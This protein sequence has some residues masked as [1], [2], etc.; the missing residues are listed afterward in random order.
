MSGGAVVMLLVGGLGLWGGL[1]VAVAN[2]WRR[3]R[4]DPAGPAGDRD[5]VL[6]TPRSGEDDRR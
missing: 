2:F 5:G 6:D 1:V 3:S 4:R